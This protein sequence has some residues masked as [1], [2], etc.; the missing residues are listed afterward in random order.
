VIDD[1]VRVLAL[2]LWKEFNYSL[3]TDP[4][5]LATF[6]INILDGTNNEQD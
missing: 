4:Q 5:A 3:P 6:V 2:A 1:R